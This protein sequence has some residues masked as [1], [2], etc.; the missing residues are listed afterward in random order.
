MSIRIGS[1]NIR[2]LGKDYVGE[3]R[4]RWFKQDWELEIKRANANIFERTLSIKKDR[5]VSMGGDSG[6]VFFFK[7]RET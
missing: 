5:D 6:S 4:G 3:G 2:D 7:S 1:K